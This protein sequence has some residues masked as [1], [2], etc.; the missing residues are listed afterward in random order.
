MSRRVRPKKW[1]DLLAPIFST[2][3]SILALVIAVLALY[4]QASSDTII[5]IPPPN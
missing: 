4:L 3:I 5:V 2:V 1:V